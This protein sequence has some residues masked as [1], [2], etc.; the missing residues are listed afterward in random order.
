MYLHIYTDGSQIKKPGQPTKTGYGFYI[1]EWD[2]RLSQSMTGSGE[3]NNR[4]ELTAIIHA[5]ETVVGEIDSKK[6]TPDYPHRV[7]VYTDSQYALQ[8]IKKWIRNTKVDAEINAPNSDLLRKMREVL[9]KCEAFVPVE[10]HKVQ[11]HTALTDDDAIGNHIADELANGA[12]MS[13]SSSRP[14]FL[15]GKYKGMDVGVAD[16]GYISWVRREMMNGSQWTKDT[17]TKANINEIL[18]WINKPHLL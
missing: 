14:I 1:R 2:L 8:V 18:D 12:A 7:I 16:S 17:K 9:Q 15:F 13:S 4:A 10:F 6:G 5:I 3:T 11:A